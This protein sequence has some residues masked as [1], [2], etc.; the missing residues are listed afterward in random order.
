MKAVILAAK[1]KD[2]LFPFTQSKPTGL[3]PIAGKPIV[4]HLIDSLQDIG[5]ED[6]YI[7][8][9]YLEEEYEEEFGEY[10]NVNTVHQEELE[11]TGTAL[12]TCDFLEGEFI[13]VNGDVI[14]STN[15]LQRL[16]EKHE[17]ENSE[18]TI[19]A[20]DE[21]KPEKFGVLSITNDKVNSI[22]EK[23]EDAENTLVNTGIY[24]LKDNV[25]EKIRET[26]ERDLTEAISDLT[27]GNVRFEIAQNYWYDIGSLRKLWKADKVKREETVE[28]TEIHE[29]AEVHES[30]YISGKA[31]IK[32]NTKIKAGTTLE[33]RVIIDKNCSV[34][35][36]TLVK[37]SSISGNS[38]IRNA[39]VENTFVFEEAIIDPEVFVENSILGED[40]DIKAGTVIEESFLGPRGFIQMNNSMRGVKTVPDAR[41][42]LS[43]ISK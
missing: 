1:K 28:E 13:V 12:A 18:A 42:D 3:L 4:S 22:E 9:N 25:F 17:S 27:D 35:P 24:V 37:D 34:G 26:E 6:I 41:T 40:I 33:G 5:V 29:S 32:A 30:A 10:T 31:V 36:G 7:V 8:T 20:S 2:S 19:L 43:E 21:S 23:P 39:T 11:G 15:D 38:Q 16:K 14:V